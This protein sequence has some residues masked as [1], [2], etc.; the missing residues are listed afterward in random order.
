MVIFEDVKDL[1][2]MLLPGVEEAPGKEL[3]AGV[4]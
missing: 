4:S 3:T 1:E 2:Y